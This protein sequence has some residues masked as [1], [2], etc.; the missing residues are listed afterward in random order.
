MLETRPARTTF[1]VTGAAGFIGSH[2]T[3][4]VLESRPDCRVI[5]VD[6]LTYAGSLANLGRVL[7]SPRHR[8]VQADIC[9]REA[10][11]PLVNEADVL[12][13]FAAETHVDRAIGDGVAF[14]RTDSLGAAVLL[15]CFR[16]AGRGRLFLQV[17]TDEV[18]GPIPAGAA[19]EDAP[20]APTNPYA[21]TKAG[22]DLLALAWVATH[23]APVIVTRGA[24]TYG[25]RQHPEKMVPTFTRAAL[26]GRPLPLYGDGLQVR[27]WLHVE[28]HCKA[29]LLLVD[30]GTPGRIYNIG[31]SEESTNLA[32]AHRI[33]DL[34]ERH[35]GIRGR[36]TH[37]ADR[38]GH[39]RRY[40]LDASLMEALGWKS[41]VRL[42]DGL[43]TT[44][45]WVVERIS[46]MREAPAP[47][48]TLDLR[49]RG[50]DTQATPDEPD[51]EVDKR[52]VGDRHHPLERHPVGDQ[53]G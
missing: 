32:M 26:A 22:A 53:L 52:R 2:F 14:A 8:F 10:M 21:A 25:P 17:S 4:Q 28:D 37:V 38:P 49:V 3:E 7:D 9:D 41:R 31:S 40:G 16:Q 50:R 5:S 35:A 45:R 23:G 42:D 11:A 6:K 34:V 15:E 46:G 18:Y 24:N 13:N 43:E 48:G 36:I 20:L 19:A 51:H 47:V 12:V 44:V 29:L 33:L 1:L 27:N 39:D 30:R